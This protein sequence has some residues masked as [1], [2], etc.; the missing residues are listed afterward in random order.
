MLCLLDNPI[1]SFLGDNDFF[2]DGGVFEKFDFHNGEII[3]YKAKTKENVGWV[4]S[5][6][7]TNLDGEQ[8]SFFTEFFEL[9]DEPSYIIEFITD[10]LK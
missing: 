4:F 2:F 8:I 1:C 6:K 5:R 10:Y 9:E 7:R 3:N